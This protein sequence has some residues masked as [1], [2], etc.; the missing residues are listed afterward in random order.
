MNIQNHPLYREVL[1]KLGAAPTISRVA[2]YL[3]ESST[4]TWR[5]V[6]DGHLKTLVG[7]G[8][9]RISLESLVAFLTADHTYELTHKR[10][11]KNKSE[12]Q[13]RTAKVAK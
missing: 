4:T 6:R 3:D 2:N 9:V 13:A 10:G 8:N 7:K 5:R 1:E 11:R 12:K